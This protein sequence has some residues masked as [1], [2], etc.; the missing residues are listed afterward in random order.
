[1]TSHAALIAYN[2]ADVQVV[3]DDHAFTWLTPVASEGE[4]IAVT[5]DGDVIFYRDGLY[6]VAFD[7]WGDPS[8]DAAGRVRVRLTNIGSDLA[9]V[10][11]LATGNDPK[12]I[13]DQ[14][15]PGVRLNVLHTLPVDRWEAGNILR[16]AA[17]AEQMTSGDV[18]FEA[19]NSVV[20][21]RRV[22]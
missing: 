12:N 1:M 17:E 16:L 7:L 8:E 20:Y 3:G 21:V 6:S 9:P 10:S 2:S 13:G 11:L 18:T 14:V 15:T 5:A 19:G 22:G 4:D